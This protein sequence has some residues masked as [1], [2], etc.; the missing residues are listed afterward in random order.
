MFKVSQRAKHVGLGGAVADHCQQ[1]DDRHRCGICLQHQQCVEHRQPQEVELVGGRLD[2]LAGLGTG[3][4]RGDAAGWWLGKVGPQLQQLGQP[5]IG[6]GGQ[7]GP[8]RD[9]RGVFGHC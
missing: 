9:I 7:P 3:G 5:F 4:Q 2:R 6:Q 1:P 8:Q